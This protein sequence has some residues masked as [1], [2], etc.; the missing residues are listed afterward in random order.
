MF[1]L[2][3]GCRKRGQF[4]PMPGNPCYYIQ[5]D[6]LKEPWEDAYGN[7]PLDEVIRQCA[8]GTSVPDDFKGGYE[9]P[10]TKRN[11]MCTRKYDKTV[12]LQQS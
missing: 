2:T 8:P 10:C 12:P 4:L 5:C 11:K 3:E 1:L 9:N 7:I 6:V